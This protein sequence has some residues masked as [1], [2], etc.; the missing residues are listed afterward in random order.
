ME[1]ASRLQASM[2][3]QL[4]HDIRTPIGIIR[5]M[6][7]FAKEDAGDTEKLK[8]DL[9]SI[10]AG[11]EMLLSLI[12]NLNDITSGYQ[13]AITLHPDVLDYEH[14]MSIIYNVLSPLCKQKGIDFEMRRHIQK[15]K[16]GA[17]R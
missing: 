4:N 5:S 3:A 15:C 11:S 17:R 10:E 2:L 14:N 16:A 1:D 7:S 9:A 8:K 13:G 6:A 12:S